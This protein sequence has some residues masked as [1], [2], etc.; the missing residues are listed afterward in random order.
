MNQRFGTILSVV[1]HLAVAGAFV[2][3]FRQP[4]STQIVAAGEGEGSGDG[5][6]E[7][8]T[9]E[10]GQLGF[11]Q[12]R[13]VSY[14]GEKP[15]E[16]NNEVIEKAEVKPPD[17]AEVLPSETKKR[18]KEKV[19]TTD[20]PVATQNEQLYSKQPL[21]GGSANTSVDVGRTFG[22]PVP[23]MTSGVGV[24]AGANLGANG[25]PGGSEYGRR[26]QQILSRNYI[27][28]IINDP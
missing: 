4:F 6:I 16:A 23:A 8:G 26:I 3:F 18:P 12:P 24:G 17:D 25:L 20:R 1:L 10:G 28:P 9:V 21:R 2:L 19:T 13:A 15:D 11:T 14:L 5:V 22:N 7:V 27:P